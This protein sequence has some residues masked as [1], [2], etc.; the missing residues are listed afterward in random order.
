M[1]L[2]TIRYENEQ[3][4]ISYQKKTKYDLIILII[5]SPS[6]FYDDF[7]NLWKSYM[8]LFPNVKAFFLYA[9]DTIGSDILISEDRITYN[10]KESYIPGI[11]YKTIAGY[12]VCQKLLDYKYVLRTN[13]SSFIH[14]P[15][16]LAYLEKQPTRD[17][18]CCNLEHFPL[19]GNDENASEI[20]ETEK[21]WLKVSNDLQKFEL[22]KQKWKKYTHILDEFFQY[23]NFIE[24][25]KFFHYFAGSFFVFTE[26]VVQKIVDKIKNEGI[27]SNSEI[28]QIPDDIA[29]SAIVQ[30]KGI[31]PRHLVNMLQYSHPCECIEKP[32][33]YTDDLFH[34]RNRTDKTFGN[35]DVDVQNMREQIRTFYSIEL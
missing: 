29:I 9:D 6:P 15:R 31:Q 5:A 28:A 1:Q 27:L 2:N 25:N 17:F 11:F 16:L 4:I 14:I 32:I 24:N 20:K 18:V 8:E 13:L 3:T 30:V 21:K 23:I 22:T 26:D 7:T 35:R 33:H 10:C 34:I 12:F 19:I